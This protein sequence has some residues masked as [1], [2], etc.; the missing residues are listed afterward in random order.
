MTE[1]PPITEDPEDGQHNEAQFAVLMQKARNLNLHYTGHELAELEMI[2]TMARQQRGTS[3]PVGCYG[4]SFEPTDRRCRICQLQGP[5]AELDQRPRVEVLDPQQLESVLCEA[6]GKGELRLELK[7]PESQE[8]RD[9]GCTN[10]SCPNT[11]GIQCGWMEKASQTSI[12]FQAKPKK[13]VVGVMEPEPEPEDEEDG[14]EEEA[15]AEVVAEPA[16]VKPEPV[17]AAV[18]HNALPARPRLR[19]VKK[20]PEPA[21]VAPAPK[22]VVAPVPKV[23]ASKKS[24]GRGRCRSAGGVKF[25]MAGT[26]YNSLSAVASEITKNRAW[27]GGRFFGVAVADLHVGDLL[28]R[29]WAGK[30]IRVEVVEE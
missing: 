7:T 19:I 23:K 24:K 28:Q 22:T 10:S 1:E 25:K 16:A 27:S 2:V 4:V 11:L 17:A 15:E 12:A 9:Y 21:V 3:H 5:C 30:V 8:V 13:R 26:V 29:K 14:E 18:D 6:C 20:V